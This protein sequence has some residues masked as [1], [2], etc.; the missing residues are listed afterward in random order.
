[1]ETKETTKKQS[2]RKYICCPNCSAVL[3]QAEEIKNAVTK[4]PNCGKVFMEID[5][6]RIVT[7]AYDEQTNS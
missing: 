4:C 7:K 2:V 6:G 5:N 3:I 1:M